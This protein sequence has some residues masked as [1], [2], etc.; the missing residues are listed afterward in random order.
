MS[1]RWAEH[2]AGGIGPTLPA[3]CHR[4]TAAVTETFAGETIVLRPRPP[5]P[6]AIAV[7]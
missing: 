4:Q 1:A 2:R 6:F 3:P 5:S 7:L